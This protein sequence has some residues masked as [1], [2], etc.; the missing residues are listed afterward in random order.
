MHKQMAKVSD[1]ISLKQS[2]DTK[3]YARA[4]ALNHTRCIKPICSAAKVQLN[5]HI[6]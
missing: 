2:T 3:V 6:L 1:Y 4:C 5:Y